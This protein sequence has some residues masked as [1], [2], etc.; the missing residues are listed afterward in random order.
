MVTVFLLVNPSTKQCEP[1]AC[2][3]ALQI[4]EE[5]LKTKRIDGGTI[6]DVRVYTDSN[7]AWKLVK[8]KACLL[9][10]SSCYTLQEMLLRLPPLG[11]SANMD[12]L[13]PLVHSFGQLN[14]CIEP[15][16]VHASGI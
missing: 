13:H 10:M 14:G 3:R 6:F 8:S 12:I 4:L 11:Y 15:L 9:E 2:A 16:G 5:Y 7:Y 1:F